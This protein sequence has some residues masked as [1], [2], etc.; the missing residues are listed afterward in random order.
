MATVAAKTVF[1]QLRSALLAIG[2]RMGCDLSTATKPQRVALFACLALL[3]V[4]VKAL[5]DNGVL[6]T[7]QLFAAR[8]AALAELWDD[9]PINPP[10]PA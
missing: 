3:S 4:V 2:T 10:P 9:E 1:T 5:V 8:D 7:A 6:T